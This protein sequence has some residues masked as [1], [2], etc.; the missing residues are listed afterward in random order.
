MAHMD[1]LPPTSP[2]LSEKFFWMWELETQ[3]QGRG[4]ARQ[5][6]LFHP[7]SRSCLPSLS[8][9]LPCSVIQFIDQLT[10]LLQCKLIFKA[11]ELK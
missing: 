8:G 9:R 1:S 10:A 11:C 4:A 2:W 7:H 3:Q 6:F 5:T